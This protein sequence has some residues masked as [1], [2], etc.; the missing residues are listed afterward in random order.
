[1]AQQTSDRRTRRCAVTEGRTDTMPQMFDWIFFAIILIPC[2]YLVW[3]WL[4][5]R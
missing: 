5:N 4:K 2:A 1:M 3:D